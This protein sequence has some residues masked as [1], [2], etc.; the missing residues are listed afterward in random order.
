MYYRV[1]K[2]SGAVR[3]K[4]PANSNNPSVGRIG[5]D[6]VPPPHTAVSIMRCISRTEELDH[7]KQLQLFNNIS[8]ESPIGKGHVSL[9]TSDYPGSTPEDPMAFVELPELVVSTQYATFT[10]RLRVI[11][12]ESGSKFKSQNLL[13]SPACRSWLL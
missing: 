9:L 12:A 8:S 3:S 2:M 7:S 13:R 5:V 6:T 4:H 10:K 1:Y 11:H